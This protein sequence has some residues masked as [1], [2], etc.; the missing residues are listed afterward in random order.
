MKRPYQER[1]ED[2]D[3][4]PAPTTS[5]EFPIIIEVDDCAC[6]TAIRGDKDVCQTPSKRVRRSTASNSCDCSSLNLLVKAMERVSRGTSTSSAIKIV[7]RVPSLCHEIAPESISRS[8]LDDSSWPENHPSPVP[9]KSIVYAKREPRLPVLAQHSLP[10]FLPK[11]RPL[12]PPPRLPTN[13]QPG[14][15]FPRKNYHST[16]SP[17]TR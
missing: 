6:D 13:M 10:P 11:G 5:N 12:M 1:N 16:V 7:D 14:Q 9:I 4:V 3:D 8:A 2:T 17:K 15:I